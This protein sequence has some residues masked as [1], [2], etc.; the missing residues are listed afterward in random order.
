MKRLN[1]KKKHKNRK[2]TLLWIML[3]LFL[4][5]SIFFTIQTATS[6]AYISELEING[7]E[8][9]QENQ[10]LKSKII[11]LSSLSNLGENASE[12]GFTKPQK[13]IYITKDATVA[14]VQ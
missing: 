10:L 8:I 4:S 14:K 12:L 1:I 5:L 9:M 7:E 2:T 13:V 3:G 11:S 6:G